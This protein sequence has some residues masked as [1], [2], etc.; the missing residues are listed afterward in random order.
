MEFEKQCLFCSNYKEE[1]MN[2]ISYGRI[3]VG[4][5]TVLNTI[6]GEELFKSGRSTDSVTIDVRRKSF[7]FEEN[8]INVYDIPGL[9]D[10]KGVSDFIK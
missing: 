4:K 1:K 2:I 5:S 3:G 6:V 9:G 8:R 7:V 10:S